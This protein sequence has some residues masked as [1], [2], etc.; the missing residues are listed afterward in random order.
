[1]YLIRT[2]IA[3]LRFHKYSV[4]NVID[5]ATFRISLVLTA[6]A[7]LSSSAQLCFLGNVALS[8]LREVVRCWTPRNVVEHSRFENA[9]ALYTKIKGSQLTRNIC[10]KIH[11]RAGNVFVLTPETAWGCFSN[12]T[13]KVSSHE[14]WLTTRNVIH[15]LS[16]SKMSSSFCAPCRELYMRSNALPTVP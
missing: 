8:S 9:R 14:M 12:V 6:T 5:F 2:A 3:V 15:G 1:M 16:T 13:F 10:S 7:A 11:Y 4:K